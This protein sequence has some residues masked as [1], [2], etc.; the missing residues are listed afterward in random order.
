[1][2]KMNWRDLLAMYYF[3]LDWWTRAPL[4]QTAFTGMEHGVSGV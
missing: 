4:D 3:G 1:M 2:G